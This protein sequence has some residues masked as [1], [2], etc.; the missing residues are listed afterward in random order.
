MKTYIYR[1][2]E[3]LARIARISNSLVLRL[4]PLVSIFFLMKAKPNDALFCL[5]AWAMVVT[6]MLTIKRP[7]LEKYKQN[8][9]AKK[10]R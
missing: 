3:G 6:G 2:G 9:H 1:I 5:T 7:P 8:G 10:E 4:A